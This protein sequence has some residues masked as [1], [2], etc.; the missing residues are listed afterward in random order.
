MKK[1]R[2]LN[3]IMLLLCTITTLV[4]NAYDFE[5]DGIYYNRTSS[6]TV[7]VTYN[8]IGST[9]EGTVVIPNTVAYN[10]VNYTV[11]AIGDSAFYHSCFEDVTIPETVTLIG[12]GAFIQVYEPEGGGLK[13]TCL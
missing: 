1:E 13:L 7:E 3:L 4:A 10:G 2:L 11:T 8:T 12:K 5:V 6:N 9:Y